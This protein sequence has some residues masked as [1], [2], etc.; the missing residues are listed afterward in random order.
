MRRGYNLNSRDIEKLTPIMEGIIYRLEMGDLDDIELSIINL[1][2]SQFMQLLENLGYERDKSR[3]VVRVET[4]ILYVGRGVLE[5]FI[6]LMHII[7]NYFRFCKFSNNN[8]TIIMHERNKLIKVIYL[9]NVI[10]ITNSNKINITIIR[11][12]IHKA[13]I[14]LNG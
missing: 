14:F 11:N 7:K 8:N 5:R 1:G 6:P 4:Y 3:I 9:N 10:F 2:P 13:N 12:F